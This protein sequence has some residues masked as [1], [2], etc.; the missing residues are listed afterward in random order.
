MASENDDMSMS[1]DRRS[2]GERFIVALEKLGFQPEVACWF[3][4]MV[5]HQFR[6]GIVHPIV[7]QIGVQRFYRALVK[8]YNVSVLPPEIKPL[9]VELFSPQSE[10]AIRLRTQM[11][12]YERGLVPSPKVIGK[13]ESGEMIEMPAVG[14]SQMIVGD[15]AIA[16]S[17]IY[18]A[19][20]REHSVNQTLKQFGNFERNV[21]RLAA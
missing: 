14:E 19:K 5:V 18:R 15:Y 1:D 20:W 9:M 2:G 7:D 10:F 17:W 6:F 12:L 11:P 4:D 13:T 16:P 21:E 8:A 3:E